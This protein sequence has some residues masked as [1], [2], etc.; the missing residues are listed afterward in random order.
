[1]KIFVLDTDL[2]PDAET[3]NAALETLGSED[4]VTSLKVLENAAETVFDTAVTK[5]IAAD[6]VVT[7]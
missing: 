6:L 3:V 4:E 5:I 7:L 2:F 1:M